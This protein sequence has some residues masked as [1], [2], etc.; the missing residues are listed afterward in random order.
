MRRKILFFL[1]CLVLLT[2]QLTIPVKA[3]MGP[4]P[5]VVINFTGLTG[6][7]YY[8]TLLSETASTGPHSSYDSSHIKRIMENDADNAIWEKFEFY[9]DKDGFYFLQYFED[10]S[11]DSE[12]TWGY[13]PPERFKILLY[14]PEENKFVGSEEIYERYA[15]DSYYSVDCNNMDIRSVIRIAPLEAERSY[16]YTWE[17]I[18]L[19]LRI[20]AT[21]IIELWI[22]LLFGYRRKKQLFIIIV[23][24]ILTQTMLNVILNLINYKGG[25]QAFEFHYIWMELLI[26][27]ME[28]CAYSILLPRYLYKG[29]P[30]TAA[31]ISMYAFTANTASYIVGLL[32]AY[33]IP[34]IF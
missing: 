21:I 19:I 23:I 1:L 3:D 7:R 26:F 16:D 27:V 34:G 15:F 31:S 29:K 25:S 13:Y 8:V 30:L 14:F 33:L 20:I 9:Q 12:F 11:E 17:I 10:C 5:S 6:E 24:N 28:A 22:A 18:S 4:K 2:F 32:L